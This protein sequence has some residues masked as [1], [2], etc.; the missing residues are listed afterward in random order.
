VIV[1]M[2]YLLCIGC[3][4]W[5]EELCTPAFINQILSGGSLCGKSYVDNIVEILLC[6]DED[7]ELS[8]RT[9]KHIFVFA[10]DPLSLTLSLSLSLFIPCIA[11]YSYYSYHS[12][13]LGIVCVP[14]LC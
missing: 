9:S 10:F 7:V 6:E 12:Y 3:V 1:V 14:H 5:R 2:P 4:C 13:M 11:S 8:A